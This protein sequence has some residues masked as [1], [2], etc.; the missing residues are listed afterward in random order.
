[1]TSEIIICRRDDEPSFQALE[2]DTFGWRPAS[3][4]SASQNLAAVLE[5][6][7]ASLQR[8]RTAAFTFTFERAALVK[9]SPYAEEP[10]GLEAFEPGADITILCPEGD[11]ARPD[12]WGGMWRDPTGRL[13]SLGRASRFMEQTR[14]EQVQDFFV[15]W[16]V[17]ELE[18]SYARRI[19]LLRPSWSAWEILPDAYPRPPSFP[20]TPPHVAAKNARL[21]ENARAQRLSDRQ[22][23]HK[24]YTYSEKTRSWSPIVRL[25]DL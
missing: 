13:N 17:K 5:I 1:M 7:I 14:V 22:F 10:Q 12:R 20:I 25:R 23:K 4:S 2:R 8:A 21:A 9:A 18:G 24:G 15:R 11:P 16:P 3:I 6:A 19:L